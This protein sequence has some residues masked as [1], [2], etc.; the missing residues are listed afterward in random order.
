MSL[1]VL[2]VSI[3]S[4]SSLVLGVAADLVHKRQDRR[5]LVERTHEDLRKI[6]ETHW[7][8]KK[9]LQPPNTDPFP[10][11]PKLPD[12]RN[13][14]G[15]PVVPYDEFDAKAG[16]IEPEMVEIR[17]LGEP[18]Q[19]TEERYVIEEKRARALDAL[20]KGAIMS[21]EQ[22]GEILSQDKAIEKIE[23]I[24]WDRRKA[25]PN[26]GVVRKGEGEDQVERFFIWHPVEDT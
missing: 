9:T 26:E 4:T 12:P 22:V 21:G 10:P 11:R 23:T 19:W 13:P 14:S 24:Y 8:F 17:H 16:I 7:A 1:E 2:L 18:D 25:L 6:K 3:A 20:A 15:R 5:A